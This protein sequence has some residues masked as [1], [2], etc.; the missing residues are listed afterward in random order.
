[1]TRTGGLGWLVLL[2]LMPSFQ[3]KQGSSPLRYHTWIV[4]VLEARVEH[5]RL[6]DVSPGGCAE[7][8][9]VQKICLK[10]LKVLEIELNRTDSTLHEGEIVEITNQYLDQKSPFA[11]GQTIRARVRLVLPEERYDPKDPRRQWWF[12][13]RGESES[14]LPPRLPFTDIRILQ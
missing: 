5:I 10:I 1:M 7:S 2:L 13:P 3:A 14:I 11:A 9:R 12:Y 4:A 6:V 8:H